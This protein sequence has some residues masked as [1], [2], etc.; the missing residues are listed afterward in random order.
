MKK[1]ALLILL[2]I[3]IIYIIGCSNFS[4][5]M[6]KTDEIGIEFTTKGCSNTRSLFRDT[7]PLPEIVRN[8]DYL[9]LSHNLSHN[10]CKNITVLAQSEEQKILITERHEGTTCRCVCESELNAA[11]GPFKSGGYEVMIY[12]QDL[13]YTTEKELL[14][15]T[16]VSLPGPRLQ[17]TG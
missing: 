14:F 7:S 11:V 16:N 8:G 12:H 10:C 2:C 15:S 4:Y 6:Q 5:V 13:D 9:Q 3:S 17:K 1:A